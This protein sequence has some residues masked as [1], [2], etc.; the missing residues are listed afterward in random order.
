MEIR[1]NK[2]ALASVMVRAGAK[3]HKTLTLVLGALSKGGINIY[4]VLREEGVLKFYVKE[5]ERERV[6]KV[7]EKVVGGDIE[8]YIRRKVGMITVTRTKHNSASITLEILMAP[9]REKIEVLDVIRSD[10]SIELFVDLKDRD[11]VF[12]KLVKKVTNGYKVRKV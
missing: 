12:N 2:N 6:V 5:N 1:M 11:Y 9:M 8:F 10:G 7:L 4:A 3:A